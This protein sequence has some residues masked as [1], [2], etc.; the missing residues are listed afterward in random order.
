MSDSDKIRELEAMLVVL[1][2]RIEKLE[3]RTRMAPSSSYL[4]E[5]KEE[6]ARLLRAWS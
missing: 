1:S 6:A 3:K 2:K 5:L 4:K